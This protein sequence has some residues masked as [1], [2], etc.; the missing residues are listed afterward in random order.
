[1]SRPSSPSLIP[2]LET[3]AFHRPYAPM[4]TWPST[5]YAQSPSL[6]GTS[7][8]YLSDMDDDDDS[9]YA[10]PAPRNSRRIYRRKGSDETGSW[11]GSLHG[12]EYMVDDMDIDE[13][14]NDSTKL[15]GEI[16]PGMNIFDSATPEMRRKRNQK[17]ST[18]V[19]M[20]LEATSLII[21]PTELVFD[22][23]GTFRRQRNIT[24][25][26]TSDSPLEGETTPEPDSPPLKKRNVRGKGNARRPRQA[27]AERDINSGHSVRG[28]RAVP[29]TQAL[30]NA[31]GPYFDGSG[32]DFEDDSLTFQ[33]QRPQRRSGLSIHRDNTGPDITFDRSTNMSYLTSGFT[34]NFAASQNSHSSVLS[35]QPTLDLNIS[36]LSNGT[37]QPP[38]VQRHQNGQL[39]GGFRAT[40]NHGLPAD[41]GLPTRDLSAFGA[42]TNHAMFP[43]NNHFVSNAIAGGAHPM[44][45]FQQHFTPTT[46]TT[47]AQDPTQDNGL[48][49]QT[50]DIFATNSAHDSTFGALDLNFSITDP[51]GLNPLW[52]GETPQAED[53]EGTISAPISEHSAN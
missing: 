23:A 12:F 2:L 38:P 5:P 28:R 50:F 10:Y 32:D 17:K 4:Q 16:W 29:R 47:T 45:A 19:V 8:G 49:L 36:Q 40:D 35:T 44:N 31:R 1:M 41:H 27:L 37:Y 53:D 7:N 11:Y 21:E 18:N 34:N 6:M 3:S 39:L 26:P 43:S 42:L 14:P 13:P 25:E 48:N 51:S 22:T 46:L 20:L 30:P 24:G 15:K 52:C 9:S 33:H